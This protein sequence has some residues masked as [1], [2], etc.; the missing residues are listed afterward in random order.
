MVW[1]LATIILPAII[2][3]YGPEIRRLFEAAR[4]RPSRFLLGHFKY[5]LT[6]LQ[7]LH[8]STYNLLLH[9]AW[10]VVFLMEFSIAYAFTLW[11][12]A[13]FK[14][15]IPFKITGMVLAGVFGRV[16]ALRE[17]VYGLHEY[18]KTTAK[19]SARIAEMEAEQ[20]DTA[21]QPKTA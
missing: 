3:A 14:P 19:L 1:L 20:T 9:L 4:K 7:R 13:L 2:T 8:G 16:I 15:D 11:L 5:R 10:N 17:T 12:V 21:T 18:D 6:L